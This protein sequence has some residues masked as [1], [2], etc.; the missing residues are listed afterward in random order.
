MT[1]TIQDK[2]VFLKQKSRK[3]NDVFP[4]DLN[5]M[6]KEKKSDEQLKN[7]DKNW[8]GTKK[9]R[10]FEVIICLEKVHVP[11]IL[12]DII[13][14]WHHESLQHRGKESMNRIIENGFK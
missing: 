9:V 13:I 8:L 3:L 10:G 4:L 7:I 11:Q 5:H 12:R 1:R 2:E 14:D 6:K